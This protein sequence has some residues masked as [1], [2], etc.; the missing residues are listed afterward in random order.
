VDQNNI[1][2][3]NKKLSISSDD[4]I[5]S[6]SVGLWHDKNDARLAK[7]ERL[8]AGTGQSGAILVCLAL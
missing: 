3:R 7:G 1:C 2:E 6:S 5:D 8:R 4:G